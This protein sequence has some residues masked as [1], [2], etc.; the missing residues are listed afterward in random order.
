MFVNLFIFILD[1]D[2]T[3]SSSVGKGSLMSI[4]LPPS[5]PLPPGV[6]SLLLFLFFP[7]KN[8][9]GSM[10]S[11]KE[12]RGSTK[13]FFLPAS[14]DLLPLRYTI[15]SLF[16]ELL[17][18]IFSFKIVCLLCYFHFDCVNVHR[19]CVIIISNFLIVFCG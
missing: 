9:G 3:S 19:L 13:F 4:L 10:I 2:H 16:P 14:P 7:A 5:V 15:H 1:D 12:Q 18:A 6:S 8:K 17:L 11:G